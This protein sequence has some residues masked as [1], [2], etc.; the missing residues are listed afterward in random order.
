MRWPGW[1]QLFLKPH[2]FFPD[3]SGLYRPLAESF[4]PFAVSY[5]IFE[6]DGKISVAKASPADV[7]AVSKMLNSG[8]QQIQPNLDAKPVMLSKIRKEIVIIVSSGLVYVLIYL[9]LTLAGKYSE[10]P[11]A[12]GNTRIFNGA[13]AVR[14]HY[15]WEPRYMFH[16]PYDKNFLG[17]IYWPLITLDRK[18]WHRSI[19]ASELSR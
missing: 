6:T 14:D 10:G 18:L 5:K 13:W 2:T 17:F 12:S 19:P 1:L 7:D 3:Q 4:E 15:V 16:R 9:L 8:M 11:V